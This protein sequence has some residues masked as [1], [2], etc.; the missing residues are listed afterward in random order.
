MSNEQ[1]RCLCCPICGRELALSA[2]VPRH[3]TAAHVWL[4]RKLHG[5]GMNAPGIAHVMS[6]TRRAVD[7]QVWRD[8]QRGRRH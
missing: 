5:L 7:G 6:T 2:P 8:A 3:W 4:A 1:P